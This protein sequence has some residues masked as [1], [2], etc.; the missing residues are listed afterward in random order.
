MEWLSKIVGTDGKPVFNRD[1][2]RLIC[3]KSARNEKKL[4]TKLGAWAIS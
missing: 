2:I 3:S 4:D 1:E